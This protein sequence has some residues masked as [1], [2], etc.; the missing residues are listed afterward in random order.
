MHLAAVQEAVM[1]SALFWNAARLGNGF[2]PVRRGGHLTQSVSL[3]RLI[4]HHLQ[5][6][7]HHQEAESLILIIDPSFKDLTSNL[8]LVDPKHNSVRILFFLLVFRP[9]CSEKV[10][11]QI[12]FEM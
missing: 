7:A 5:F 12:K 4:D 8:L 9:V 2:V 10:K 6:D 11:L 1:H 3:I